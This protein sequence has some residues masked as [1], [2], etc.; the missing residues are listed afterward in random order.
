[1]LDW[2]LNFS[3]KDRK[4]TIIS[5]ELCTRFYNHGNHDQLRRRED[6][7][8]FCI[9]HRYRG[10]DPVCKHD[11]KVLTCKFRSY[12]LSSDIECSSLPE[13]NSRKYV[14]V[15]HILRKL[16]SDTSPPNDPSYRIFRIPNIE[17]RCVQISRIQNIVLYHIPPESVLSCCI[18]GKEFSYILLQHDPLLCNKNMSELFSKLHWEIFVLRQK[19]IFSLTFYKRTA[20]I[21]YDI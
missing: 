10:S 11:K 20:R 7:L 1:M 8:D 18:D 14:R 12:A 21:I 4:K 9:C 6:I 2:I 15:F 13:N 5:Y 16:E 3:I 17:M 19:E